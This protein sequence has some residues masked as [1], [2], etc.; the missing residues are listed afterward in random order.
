M[1]EHERSETSWKRK[2]SKLM[3]EHDGSEPVIDPLS[4]MRGPRIM[5]VTPGNMSV[6][7]QMNDAMKEMNEA[8]KIQGE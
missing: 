1:K 2:P 3:I 4:N 5:E 6:S 7:V 8:K